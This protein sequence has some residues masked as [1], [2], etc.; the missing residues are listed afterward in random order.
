MVGELDCCLTE[1]YAAARLPWLHREPHG[2][3]STIP[4]PTWASRH[5]RLPPMTCGLFRRIGEKRVLDPGGEFSADR[6]AGEIVDF[7]G[8]LKING[9]RFQLLF[10][11][12]FIRLMV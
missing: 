12:F 8:Q 11:G 1:K 7:C 4:A 3:L 10:G 6:C 5:Q 2:L 9:F